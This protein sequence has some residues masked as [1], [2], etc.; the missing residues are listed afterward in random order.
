MT[1]PNESLMQAVLD[2]PPFVRNILAKWDSF[3]EELQEHHAEHAE[4]LLRSA[5][6]LSRDLSGVDRARV[7]A[8]LNELR[9]LADDLQRTIGLQPDDFLRPDDYAPVAPPTMCTRAWRFD[10]AVRR[11]W[12]LS[13]ASSTAQ[14]TN[15]FWTFVVVGVGFAAAEVF[16]RDLSMWR[17]QVKDDNVE[18]T[19]THSANA[20]W[21]PTQTVVSC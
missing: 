21:R 3:D 14:H 4:W 19:R 6:D 7:V 17:Q 18:T 12:A 5:R 20:T 1:K 11:S 15:H 2:A 16:R 10:A 8:V 9:S 13:A